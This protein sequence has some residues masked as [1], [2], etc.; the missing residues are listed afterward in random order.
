VSWTAAM[1]ARDLA[2]GF[3]IVTTFA[4][5]PDYGEIAALVGKEA[6]N[7]GVHSACCSTIASCA[8]VSAAYAS[9]A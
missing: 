1:E 2:R 7:S 3:D 5:R 8:T 9:A 4:K 6:G